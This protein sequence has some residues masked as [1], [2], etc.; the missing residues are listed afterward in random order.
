MTEMTGR[1]TRPL[2]WT[3]CLARLVPRPSVTHH[4]GRGTLPDLTQT[5]DTQQYICVIAI[6]ILTKIDT[7]TF[8]YV[9][10]EL[11]QTM[12]DKAHCFIIIVFKFVLN[13]ILFGTKTYAP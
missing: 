4:Q 10:S 5:T 8:T 12:S 11:S 7:K 6:L 9:K 13:L 1:G 3:V 2:Q